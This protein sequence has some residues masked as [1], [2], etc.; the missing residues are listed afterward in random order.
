MRSSSGTSSRLDPV[1]PQDVE[2]LVDHPAAVRGRAAAADPRLEEREVGLAVA[3]SAIT[4]PS[5]IASADRAMSPVTGTARSSRRRP[6]GRGSR[7][8]PRRRHDGFDPEPVPL[9][10]VSQ[11]GSSNGSRTSVASIGGMKRSLIGRSYDGSFARRDHSRDRTDA[12]EPLQ[13]VRV[14]RPRGST[15]EPS[16]R[17]LVVDDTSTSPEPGERHHPRCRVDGQAASV[18][19]DELDLARMD[20]DADRQ[21]GLRADRVIASAAAN[22]TRRAIEH[23]Q[24]PI[25][26]RRDLA[27]AEALRSSRRRRLWVASRSRHAA[28]P[29]RCSGRGRVRRCR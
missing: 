19:A 27:P 20:A 14:P 23:G 21:A 24:E 3:S 13:L 25:A 28:S 11:A 15:P 4:S 16:R 10:L 22:G 1:Q 6:G 12:R 2:H 5:R 9:D 8:G 29:I 26:G 18:G 17:S 7:A